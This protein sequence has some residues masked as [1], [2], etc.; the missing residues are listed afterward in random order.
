M[1]ESAS[2]RMRLRALGSLQFGNWG[3]GDERP[4]RQGGKEARRQDKANWRSR[5][6]RPSAVEKPL[7]AH[8]F[9]EARRLALR[10]HLA[11]ADWRRSSFPSNFNTSAEG[12]RDLQLEC[13]RV[14]SIAYASLRFSAISI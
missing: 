4:R 6:R 14:S 10:P 3:A 2:R 9:L 5:T 11:R 12:A 1:T 8:W 13:L 7:S